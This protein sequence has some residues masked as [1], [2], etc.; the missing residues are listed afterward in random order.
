M[1]PCDQPGRAEGGE[2]QADQTQDGRGALIYSRTPGN[3]AEPSP[4]A[5]KAEI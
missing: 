2:E 4:S 3:S 5:L 1:A